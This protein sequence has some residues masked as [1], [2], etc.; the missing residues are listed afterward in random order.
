MTEYKVK[1]DNP[2]WSVSKTYFKKKRKHIRRSL[3]VLQMEMCYLCKKEISLMDATIDHV[4]PKSILSPESQYNLLNLRV[5]CK[6]CNSNKSD[7]LL[8]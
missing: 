4:L 7:S 6:K 3:W 1:I 5:A 2:D 8:N